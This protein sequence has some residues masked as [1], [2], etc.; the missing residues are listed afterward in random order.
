M[1]LTFRA[2]LTVIVGVAAVAFVI[3]IVSSAWLSRRVEDLMADVELRQL[4]RLEIGPRLEHRLEQLQRSFQDAVAARDVEA[5]GGT[6]QIEA[7]LLDEILAARGVVTPGEAA[8]LRG[9]VEDYYLSA[10]DISRRLVGGETGE[11][12]V[13]AMAAM[14][15]KQA[16]AVDLTKSITAP[17][18]RQLTESFQ[19][20]SRAQTAAGRARVAI[21][22]LCMLLVVALSIWMSRGVLR[23]L[24]ALGTG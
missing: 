13:E 14:Q 5:L 6:R 22:G 9:A 17:D 2:K 19:A 20:A 15:S 23:S 4:P 1:R 21:G 10:L 12:L 18:R 16:K 24:A 11:A 3:T 8:V 7:Q